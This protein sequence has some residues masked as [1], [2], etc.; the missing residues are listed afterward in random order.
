M[1]AKI[2]N[3]IPHEF[4]W[5][6]GDVHIYQNHLSQVE[7]YLNSPI[8]DLPHLTINGDQKQIDDFKFEDFVLENYQHGKFIKASIAV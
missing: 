7:E 8:F 4:I 1:I 3:T 6:G 5:T 2:T